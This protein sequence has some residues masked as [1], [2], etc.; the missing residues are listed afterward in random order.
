MI[1]IKKVEIYECSFCRLELN[2]DDIA[3]HK[4]ICTSDPENKGCFTCC[5]REIIPGTWEMKCKKISLISEDFSISCCD[6]WEPHCI[7]GKLK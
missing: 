4:K 6:L 7:R 3:N 1:E 2:P 5:Y